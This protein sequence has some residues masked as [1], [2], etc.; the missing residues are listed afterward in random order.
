MITEVLST[1]VVG[2][3][4][5]MRSKS[6]WL[7]LRC[8]YTSVCESVFVCMWF[9]LKKLRIRDGSSHEAT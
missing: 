8:V 5:L 9:G 3:G 7:G 4:W 1:S 2:V 6:I